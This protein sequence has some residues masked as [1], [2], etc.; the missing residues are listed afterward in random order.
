K[1]PGITDLDPGINNGNW[2]ATPWDRP[3]DLSVTVQYELSSKWAFGGNFIFQ[4][5]KPI[6]LPNGQYIYDGMMIPTYEARNSSRIA[7]YHRMDLSATL[8]PKS[9][10]SRRWKGE[11]VFSVYNVYNKKNAAS[12]SF[13]ENSE[14]FENEAVRLSIF[15]I[16][17][18]VTYNF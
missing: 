16:I 1:T 10:E 14:T 11:W 17:P 13:R 15:G 9:R 4:N 2:Y 3:H 6:T 7:S 18:S 5:G 8:T 12:I